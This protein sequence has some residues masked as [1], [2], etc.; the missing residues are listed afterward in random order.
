MVRIISPSSTVLEEEK[1]T[2]KPRTFKGFLFFEEKTY[3]FYIEENPAISCWS[4][5]CLCIF[6]LIYLNMYNNTSP[7]SLTGF[8]FTLQVELFKVVC[9]TLQ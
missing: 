8:L 4:I 2:I 5:S 7:S 9:R 3:K 6:M 1:K